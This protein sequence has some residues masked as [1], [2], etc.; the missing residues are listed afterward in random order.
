[1]KARYLQRGEALDY[2]NN[3]EEKI[4]AGD[5]VTIGKRIG[6]AGTEMAPGELGT[7]HVDGVYELDKKDKTAM[8][9][10]T[11]VYLAADGITATAGSNVPAGFVAVDSPA[12]STTV[13]VKINA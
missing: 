5:V 7:I 3:T 9:M 12:E 4:G 13:C 1:M 2:R 10:G 8:T 6:V 11:E